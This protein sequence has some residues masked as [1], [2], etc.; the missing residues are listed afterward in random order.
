MA[1]SG[2]SEPLAPLTGPCLSPATSAL[3]C[4]ASSC[5][6]L[7]SRAASPPVA[8]AGRRSSNVVVVVV[9][10]SAVIVA[11]SGLGRPVFVALPPTLAVQRLPTIDY[12]DCVLYNWERIDKQG[13]MTPENVRILNRFTGL[14]DEEWFL[15]T[16]VILESEA[17]GVVSA[18]YDACQTI[19]AND[20]DRLLPMLDWL[21][22]ANPKP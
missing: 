14:L 3:L 19:K 4:G 17:S 1:L 7:A 18:V 9:A 13:P 11:A 22:Q 5:S 20:I 21:E 2:E 15:K 8:P 16:H 6:P 12:A 10:C